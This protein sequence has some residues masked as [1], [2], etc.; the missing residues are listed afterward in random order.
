MNHDHM[1][2]PMLVGGAVL[3]ALALAGVPVGNVALLLV[4]L[5]CPLMM[6]FMMRGM[7][8]GGDK[9]DDSQHDHSR[10]GHDRHGEL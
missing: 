2:K 9:R 6:F 4:V 10:A 7:D 8:H 1:I 5:A 3:V